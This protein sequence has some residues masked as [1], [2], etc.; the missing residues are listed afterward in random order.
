MICQLVPHAA[1]Q[2]SRRLTCQIGSVPGIIYRGCI[3]SDFD[4]DMCAIETVVNTVVAAVICRD[5]VT[6]HCY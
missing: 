6:T 4:L 2:F 3:V 5:S 1:I